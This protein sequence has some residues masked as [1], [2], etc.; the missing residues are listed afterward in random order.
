MHQQNK[1]NGRLR[2]IAALL[3]VPLAC[4][5]SGCSYMVV[6]PPPPQ[7]DRLALEVY[8]APCTRSKAQP[9]VD[10]IVGGVSGGFGLLFL[11]IGAG[12]RGDEDARGV[13]SWAPKKD[14]S[15]SDTLLT[16]GV[17]AL[18]LGIAEAFSARY[19]YNAVNECRSIYPRAPRRKV[20]AP[21]ARWNAWP[22]APRP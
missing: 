8:D 17:G 21:D 10:T 11:A 16:L 5:P 15:S 12:E 1:N 18:A 9:I 14:H 19:G 7:V 2:F 22:P 6:R 4:A 3:A 13:P 20:W